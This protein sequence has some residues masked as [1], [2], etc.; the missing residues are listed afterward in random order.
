MSFTILGAEGF[1]GSH[2][3]RC[4]E[5]QSIDLRALGRGDPIDG[6]LGNVIDC[7]GVTADFRERP[8]DAMDAHVTRVVQLLE[9]AH[10]DSFLYLSSTRVYLR[11]DGGREEMVIPVNPSEPDDLY[12]ISK[13][14]GEAACLRC[15][16]PK[17]R[18]ARL[19][20]VY[21]VEPDGKTFLPSVIRS[22]IVDKRVILS[23]DEASTR[24]FVAL[25]DVVG[26]LPLIALEG[27]YRL[28][29]VASGRNFRAGE[30]V[31]QICRISDAE[32]VPAGGPLVTFPTISIDR[33]RDDLGFKPTFVTDDLTALV[34][35]YRRALSA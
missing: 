13:L 7:A 6:D 29:N 35:E 10:F 25:A 15:G 5:S 11:A 23:I 32:F 28:Y 3:A 18:V 30:L 8:N 9:S 22:A 2:L 12:A 27:M 1:I 19:S 20:N 4:L 24:D 26:V 34:T 16:N 31:R 21:G 33:I 14:A 17:V